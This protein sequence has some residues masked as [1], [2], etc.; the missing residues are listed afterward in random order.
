METHRSKP[1]ILPLL[2]ASVVVGSISVAWG[3]EVVPAAPGISRKGAPE[4]PAGIVIEVSADARISARIDNRSLSDVLRAMTTKNLFD[5]KGALPAGETVSMAFSDLT[6]SEALKKLMRG[7]NYV[8]VGQGSAT[9]PLLTVMG[10][11]ESAKATEARAVSAPSA[12]PVSQRP[13]T[14]RS[15]VPPSTMP[16]TPAPANR[17]PIPP[18]GRAARSA[19]SPGPVGASSGTPAGSLRAPG[20]AGQVGEGSEGKEPPEEEG[21]EADNTAGQA[22]GR[23]RPG[24]KDSGLGQDGDGPDGPGS[25]K[26]LDDE[27]KG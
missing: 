3:A 22:K 16:Q 25:K 11:V 5:I 2:I 6:L 7:Y 24:Q 4:Q 15:Y 14:S 13:D 23:P 20:A 19:G 27:D 8:L 18:T 21:N 12:V 1:L 9:K 26:P 10:K 17:A